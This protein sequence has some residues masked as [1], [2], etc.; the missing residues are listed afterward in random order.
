[1]RKYRSFRKPPFDLGEP[2]CERVLYYLDCGKRVRISIGRPQLFDGNEDWLCPYQVVGLDREVLDWAP[3]IDSLGSMIM[4]IEAVRANVEVS[5][6]K[7]TQFL[8]GGEPDAGLPMYI[9]TGYGNEVH[10]RLKTRV[11]TELD[12]ILREKLGHDYDERV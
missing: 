1:M 10:E 4:A 12:L 5:G 8:D 7:L 11:T 6:L 9:P 2:I 3:G